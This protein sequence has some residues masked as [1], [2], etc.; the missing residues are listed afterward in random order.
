MLVAFVEKRANLLRY[1]ILAGGLLLGIGMDA[2]GQPCVLTRTLGRFGRDRL[3]LR[4]RLLWFRADWLVDLGRHLAA[5]A[6]AGGARREGL[7][8]RREG[9][10]RDASER[11][12]VEQQPVGGFVL[13]LGET[14]QLAGLVHGHQT[15]RHR[16]SDALELETLVLEDGIV[17][18]EEGVVLD[19]E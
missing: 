7:W 14:L 5:T 12:V 6:R 13:G 10:G 19:A 4:G 2:E 9:R 15:A 3:D 11:R 1:A 8:Q 16:G 18:R 17:V